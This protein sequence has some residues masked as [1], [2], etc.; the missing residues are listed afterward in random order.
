MAKPAAPS[1]DAFGLRVGINQK[2]KTA[3]G[4]RAVQYLQENFDRLKKSAIFFGSGSTIF[5]MVQQLQ[6]SLPMPAITDNLHV[7]SALSSN[8]E[9]TVIMIGG[10]ILLPS[11]NA[12]GYLAE[13]MLSN[14][15][16]ECA[17]I[18]SSGIDESGYLCAYNL[19]ETGMFSTIVN[20]SKR[21]VILADRSKIGHS[22]MVRIC[23]LSEKFILFT[24]KTAPQSC[25][26][27]YQKMG[28]N[29]ILVNCPE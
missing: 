9:N 6:D 20:I 10:T 23:P 3:I 24:D 18:G 14:L 8:P 28:A 25:I 5:L 1:E 13:K 7:A 4:L 2:S 12:T 19:V 15:S 26:E 16:V 11:L 29:V 21:V 27:Q 22:N 17:F